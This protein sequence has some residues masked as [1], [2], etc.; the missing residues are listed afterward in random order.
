MPCCFWHVGRMLLWTCL[1]CSPKSYL[2]LIRWTLL[3]YSCPCILL[4]GNTYK[5]PGCNATGWLLFSGRSCSKS[6][7]LAVSES[8]GVSMIYTSQVSPKTIHLMDVVLREICCYVPF[9]LPDNLL[10]GKALLCFVEEASSEELPLSFSR[11][12][13]FMEHV[14]SWLQW[15]LIR[16]QRGFWGK[17]KREQCLSR[18]VFLSCS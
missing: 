8:S 14:L 3:F 12:P 7:V 4:T 1:H 15:V 6:Q 9:C 16:L 11:S 10:H 2:K 18:L 5:Q 17:C 13:A